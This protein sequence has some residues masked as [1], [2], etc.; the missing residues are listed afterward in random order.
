MS[1]VTVSLPWGENYKSGQHYTLKG[2]TEFVDVTLLQF[3]YRIT[4]YAKS[5][6]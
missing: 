5:R 4:C 6:C 1:T 2:K 3:L